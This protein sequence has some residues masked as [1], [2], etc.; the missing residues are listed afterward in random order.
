MLVA[1]TA[2]VAD[3]V[4]VSVAGF[5]L[6]LDA[7]ANGFADQAAVT[8]AGIPLT[9]KLIAPVNDP[10]VAAVKLTVPEPPSVTTTEFDAAVSASAG[11]GVTVSA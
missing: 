9:E 10:L 11:A 8:P 6:T 7:A 1:P 5:A 2:A 4:S 3:A